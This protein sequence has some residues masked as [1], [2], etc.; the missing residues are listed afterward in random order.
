MDGDWV[1]TLKYNII[2]YASESFWVDFVVFFY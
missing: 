2:I 1:E